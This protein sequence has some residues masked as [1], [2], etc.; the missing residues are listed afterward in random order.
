M[1]KRLL[2]L[3]ATHDGVSSLDEL[4]HEMGVPRPLVEQLMTELVRRGYL[5]TTKA[6]C[7]PRACAACALRPGCQPPM[8]IALWELTEKGAASVPQRPTAARAG[9][10]RHTDG[11]L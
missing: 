10:K 5:T 8:G 7:P 4:A 1:L 6:E 9:M 11:A 3:I 2:S